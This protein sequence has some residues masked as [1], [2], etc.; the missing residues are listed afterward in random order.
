MMKSFIQDIKKAAAGFAYADLGEM[1]TFEQ[2]AEVL[3]VSAAEVAAQT[4]D[5]ARS[6][7]VVL[8]VKDDLQASA[9]KY[10]VNSCLRMNA[11]LDIL[12]CCPQEMAERLIQPHLDIIQAQ[13]I[14]YFVVLRREAFSRAVTAYTKAVPDVLFV[15]VGSDELVNGSTTARESNKEAK[16]IGDLPLV[17]VMGNA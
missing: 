7:R 5:L 14:P 1:K 9:V 16:W 3:G 12:C 13:G 8:A 11:S 15:V 4:V 6:K 2:K 17:V 10:A